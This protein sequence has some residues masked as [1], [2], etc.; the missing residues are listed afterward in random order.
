MRR[1]HYT[2]EDDAIIMAGGMSDRERAALLGRSAACIRHRRSRIKSA[3]DQES[4]PLPTRSETRECLRC[5]K[6][7][8]SRGLHNRL[9]WYCNEQNSGLSHMAEGVL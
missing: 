3:G 5:G 1:R 4:R 7:F 2:P 9:C 6:K 8:R